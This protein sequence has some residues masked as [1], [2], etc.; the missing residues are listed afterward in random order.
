M[1]RRV[2]G[3]FV[4]KN[5]KVH[6]DR[7]AAGGGKI[8]NEKACLSDDDIERTV[9]EAEE[10][11]AEDEAQRKRIASMN[12]LSNFVYGVKA[13]LASLPSTVSSKMTTT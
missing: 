6:N 2:Y 11:A 12:A 9:R 8:W 3:N 4:R 7:C 1:V 5:H 10:F 13:Q